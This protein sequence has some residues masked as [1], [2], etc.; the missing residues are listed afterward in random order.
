MPTEDI[1]FEPFFHNSKAIFQIIFH[2]IENGCD[3]QKLSQC[4]RRVELID[5]ISDPLEFP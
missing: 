4:C 1:F 5:K 2:Y 3:P